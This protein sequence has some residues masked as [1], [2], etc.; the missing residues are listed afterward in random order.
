M[1]HKNDRHKITE[2]CQQHSKQGF[3]TLYKATSSYASGTTIILLMIKRERNIITTY[4][5]YYS[6]YFYLYKVKSA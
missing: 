2:F 3:Y 5:S 1:F 4:L 6:S